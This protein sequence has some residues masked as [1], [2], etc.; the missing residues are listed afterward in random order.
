MI[1]IPNRAI[2]NIEINLN[3]YFVAHSLGMDYFI[4]W[5]LR[6]RVELDRNDNNMIIGVKFNFNFN[7]NCFTLLKTKIDK[8]KSYS[9]NGTS[10]PH[11]N[12]RVLQTMYIR[13]EIVSFHTTTQMSPT[14]D[15]SLVP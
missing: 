12:H 10:S 9:I 13:K 3:N 8:F 15:S 4:R 14:N 6:L 11:R 7:I 5:L 2:N 1:E